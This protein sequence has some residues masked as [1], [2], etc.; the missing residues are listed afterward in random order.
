MSLGLSLCPCSSSRWGVWESESGWPEIV[1][2]G[3]HGD[4]RERDKRHPS[5]MPSG[6]AHFP[7]ATGDVPGAWGGR[8]DNQTQTSHA[9]CLLRGCTGGKHPASPSQSGGEGTGAHP[10]GKAETGESS[11]KEVERENGGT[12]RRGQRHAG[13]V[14]GEPG[15]PRL[16]LPAGP[17]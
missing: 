15:R 7:G 8:H 5:K 13:G 6:A 3:R 9:Q 14:R 1:S 16:D 11:R 17:T 12:P 4:Q 2:W 10:S